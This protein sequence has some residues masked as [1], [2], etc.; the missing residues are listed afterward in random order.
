MAS[1]LYCKSLI[2]DKNNREWPNHT[3]NIS[4]LTY[5]TMQIFI[6]SH[7]ELRFAKLVFLRG[8]ESNFACKSQKYL[9]DR[10][11]DLLSVCLD[12]WNNHL[13]LKHHQTYLKNQHR[14]CNEQQ[15]RFYSPSLQ[16]Q[17]Y[18]YPSLDIW[19]R[20]IAAWSFS[21]AKLIHWH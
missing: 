5:L 7:I 12:R 10:N 8:R 18:A 6:Y 14:A 1:Q 15:Y 21:E 4:T 3:P 2:S 11:K 16:W 13:T 17:L 9:N 19:N 20:S